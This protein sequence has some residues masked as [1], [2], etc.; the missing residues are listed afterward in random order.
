MLKLEVKSGS[1]AGRTLESSADLL[2]VGRAEGND[3][4]LVDDAVQNEHAQVFFDGK[5]HLLRDQGSSSGTA[6]ARG[7]NRVAIDDANGREAP[8]EHGDVIEL[9][10][11]DGAVKLAVSISIEA[12]ARVVAMRRIEELGPTTSDV[13][14][15][16]SR[17]R[18]LY[19][20]QKTIGGAGDLSD[21]LDAVIGACFSLVPKATH[22]TVVLRDDDEEGARAGVSGYVA[23]V[24]RARA[25]SGI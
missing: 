21:V 6:I 22:V 12:D 7:A 4:Q 3:L 2:R 24:T 23:V 11:G 19:D 25:G 18:A 1:S 20:V 14:R 15:D 8:L 17:M 16:Q 5:R 13:E 10:T 9:G